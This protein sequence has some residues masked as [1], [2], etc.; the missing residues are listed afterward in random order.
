VLVAPPQTR[1]RRDQRL[2]L[3]EEAPAG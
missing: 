1:Q 3:L 2:E